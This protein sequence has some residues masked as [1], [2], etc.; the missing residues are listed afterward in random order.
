VGKTRDENNQTTV[1]TELQ[2]ETVGRSSPEAYPP[3]E[4]EGGAAATSRHPR[5]SV[6]AVLVMASFSSNDVSP[7][8]AP[9]AETPTCWQKAPK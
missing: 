3:Q 6:L 8:A 7:H 4:P 2:F 5:F 9:V 1:Q